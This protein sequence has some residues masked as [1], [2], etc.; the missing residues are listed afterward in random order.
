MITTIFRNENGNLLKMNVWI[1][2]CYLLNFKEASE[3]DY[4]ENFRH[5]YKCKNSEC[6]CQVFDQRQTCFVLD[7]LD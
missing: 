6:V 3:Y 4:V 2:N 5:V 7:R 1:F